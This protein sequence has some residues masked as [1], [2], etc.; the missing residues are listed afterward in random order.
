MRNLLLLLLSVSMIV[1]AC[2]KKSTIE[3]KPKILINKYFQDDDT[4]IIICKGFPKEGLTDD[5]QK[6][7][8]AKEA[9]LLNA[10]MIARETFKDSVDVVRTGSIDSY[11]VQ[12]GFATVKYV[13]KYSGL[14]S[15]LR[16]VV[17]NIE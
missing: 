10:Q 2:G 1:F 6:S 16:E 8:T 15:N 4:F 17:P 14:K 3:D 13:L 12:D 9:A 11:E 5:I 7:E